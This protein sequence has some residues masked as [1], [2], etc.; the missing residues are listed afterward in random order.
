MLA[1][2]AM[3]F[4]SIAPYDLYRQ[5]KPVSHFM[6]RNF[7]F[8]I[9]VL[10]PSMSQGQNISFTFDDGLNPL[11]QPEAQH[12]N[13][14]LLSA[15]AAAQVKAMLFPAG[16]IV[17]NPDGMK[18]VENW[19]K[20]GHAI[21][22]HTYSHVSF[23]SPKTIL[24]NF[25]AD[26][27]RADLTFNRLPGW[28]PRLRFPYLKEGETQTKRDGMRQWMS[29][30]G[31][32]SAPVSIDT[33]DW[34]YN[35]R[36]IEWRTTH[37][38]ADTKPFREAY[39]AH[40]WTRAEYYEHLSTSLLGRSPAHVMLLHANYIN[41]TFLPDVIAMFRAHG[42]KIVSPIEAFADSLYQ[43]QPTTFP[44]GESILWALAK[45]ANYPN[46]RYPAEDAIYEE[47]IL[48]ARG[49]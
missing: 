4:A 48:S 41:A 7:F 5:L 47:P 18:L 22:N 39:L 9:A 42:W 23:G 30:Q 16:K 8:L 28:T 38:E 14:Q 3:C 44:A 40:L 36:F 27:M 29:T 31:Y 12:W 37:P 10:L 21:G 32:E 35:N 26:V 33:S 46:L 49:F 2:G 13:D 6:M 20:H 34:Y 11:I 1:Y 45:Q 17:K 15:L 19:G 24:E 43:E 25:T